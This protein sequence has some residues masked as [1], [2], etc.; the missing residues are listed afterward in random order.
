MWLPRCVRPTEKFAPVVQ[1][2]LL[3]DDNEVVAEF[4]TLSGKARPGEQSAG[5]KP[6]LSHRQA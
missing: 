5:K 2:I 1:P 4:Q 3:I 6:L